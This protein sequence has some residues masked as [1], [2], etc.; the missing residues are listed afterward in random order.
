MERIFASV[1]ASCYVWMHGKIAS[2]KKNH[3]SC[4]QLITF[5]E[6]KSI[7]SNTLTTIYKLK[8]CKVTT[9]TRKAAAVASGLIKYSKPMEKPLNI[10]VSC[11]IYP[12]Q[13]PEVVSVFVDIFE[14][15][16]A[17]NTKGVT[18]FA[19]NLLGF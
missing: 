2:V 8:D 12:M 11:N 15:L 19:L 16:V 9:R 3:V 6:T 14:L 4:Q 5:H 13:K 1:L 17:A 10:S 7:D 18:D